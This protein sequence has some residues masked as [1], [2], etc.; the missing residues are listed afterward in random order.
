MRKGLSGSRPGTVFPLLLPILY[1]VIA[2]LLLF[3]G[4][5][6]VIF[7]KLLGKLAIIFGAG[8]ILPYFLARADLDAGSC[9]FSIGAPAVVLGVCVLLKSADAANSLSVLL[10]IRIMLAAIRKLQNAIQLKFR[11][12]ARRIPVLCVSLAF[13]V[14]TVLLAVD[15]FGR[16]A[17]DRFTYI[18][19]L[20]DGAVSFANALR[21]G[22]VRQVPGNGRRT[23][24]TMPDAGERLPPRRLPAPLRMEKCS[25]NF[26]FFVFFSI[27]S[28]QNGFFT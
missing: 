8:R 6:T 19:L 28:W 9:G 3:T 11:H 7:A 20:C 23:G 12:S 21:H 17:R 24:L 15:P 10:N 27:F 2:V 16:E 22:T 26:K 14:C 1:I 13:L 4:I 18:V 25:R 5:D